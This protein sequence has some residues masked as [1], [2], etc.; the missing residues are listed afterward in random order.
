MGIQWEYDGDFLLHDDSFKVA[1]KQGYSNTNIKLM[2]SHKNECIKRY[3][4]SN[5]GIWF[6]KHHFIG[7]SMDCVVVKKRG[8]ASQV[9]KSMVWSLEL[10]VI[11]N[12]TRG[13]KILTTTRYM[14]IYI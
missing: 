2:V 4:A 8:S 10:E 5:T 6:G 11:H 1:N 3:E 7:S 9:G 14:Y 13:T 12:C